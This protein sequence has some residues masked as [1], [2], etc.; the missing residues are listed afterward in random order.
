MDSVQVLL[1]K[2]PEKR[3]L[4]G[5]RESAHPSGNGTPFGTEQA[6]GG[7]QKASITIAVTGL[8]GCF[9]MGRTFCAGSCGAASYACC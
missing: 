7:A 9:T 4:K 5:G 8:F 6:F 1:W 2:S 3:Y